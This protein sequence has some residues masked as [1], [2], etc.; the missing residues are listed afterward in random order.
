VPAPRPTTVCWGLD[1][2]AAA[3]HHSV[4]WLWQ[5]YLATGAITLLTSQW[6]SGKTT[7]VSV[8]LSRLK[9]KGEFIGLPN[10]PARALV[11][12]EEPPEHW[13]RRAKKLDLASHVGWIC[14]PFLARPRPADWLALIDDI[15]LLQK[16]K[17]INL[18]VIDPLASFLAGPSENDSAS[19]LD[20]L[21]PLQRL[22]ALGVA[23]LILHH[24]KKGEFTP[25]QAARGSGALSGAADILIEMR[26]YRHAAETDRRRRIQAF[27]RFEE[28]PR[29]L[30][31]E[32]SP[33]G[34]DYRSLGSFNEELFTNAWP[35][36]HAIL[37]DAS[38]K[39][40]RLD[41]RRAWKTPDRPARWSLH[42]ALEQAVAEGKLKKDGT[43]LKGSPFR[44]WLPERE[45]A[46]CAD[47]LAL[48]HMPELIEQLQ[49]TDTFSAALP[50]TRDSSEASKAAN[51]R[52]KGVCPPTAG[53][54]PTP[55]PPP[56]PEPP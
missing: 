19:I 11:L 20:T 2:L 49:G 14:R 51:P 32:L 54:P 6:K 37:A 1:S 45:A 9:A 50:A 18:F 31:I 4:S 12:S 43:G 8:L 56:D 35:T 52:G 22:T 39:F 41:I 30:V 34:T 55:G 23:I 24:P 33:D 28:T 15:C 40:T 10:A 13:L 3:S 7:L 26:S 44:Y 16:E 27:S 42:R 46:W 29:Q 17:A 25:G 47:P 21:L 38:R 5:G 36:I 53:C 48:L